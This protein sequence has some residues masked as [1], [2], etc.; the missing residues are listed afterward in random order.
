MDKVKPKSVEVEMPYFDDH[1][2]VDGAS[3]SMTACLLVFLERQLPRRIVGRP[4]LLYV[5]LEEEV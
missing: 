4:P 1:V 5:G 2:H 3:V